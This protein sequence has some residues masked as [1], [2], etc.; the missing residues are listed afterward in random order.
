MDLVFHLTALE[1]LQTLCLPDKSLHLKHY[2]QSLRGVKAMNKD[3]TS[4]QS[5]QKPE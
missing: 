2:E 3:E 1:S 4:L 5:L